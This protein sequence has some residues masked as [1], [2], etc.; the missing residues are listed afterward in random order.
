MRKNEGVLKN[1]IKTREDRLRDEQSR[2]QTLLKSSN[3]LVQR[4]NEEYS[5]VE[6]NSKKE[7]LS[8]QVKI[9]FVFI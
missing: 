7:I 3:D 1:S 2:Y 4:A 9:F 5:Q 8:L 6:A